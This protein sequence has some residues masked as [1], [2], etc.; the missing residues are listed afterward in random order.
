MKFDEFVEILTKNIPD[1]VD[2]YVEYSNFKGD[3]VVHAAVKFDFPYP[4]EDE[5]E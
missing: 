4:Q 2:W 1:N 5:E 3:D